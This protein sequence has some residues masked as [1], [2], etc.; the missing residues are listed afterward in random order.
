[1]PEVLRWAA[2]NLERGRPELEKQPSATAGKNTKELR[3]EKLR[4]EIRKLRAQADHEETALQK[5]RCELLDANEVERA[6]AEVGVI[7]RNEFENLPSQFVP[8]ALTNGMPHENAGKLQ[9]QVEQCVTDKLRHLSRATLKNN[10]SGG[11]PSIQEPVS[12]G[13]LATE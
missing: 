7:I 9:S 1:M 8:L 11:E 10:R 13:A 2:D 5:E 3:D 12:T 6:W 4:Q